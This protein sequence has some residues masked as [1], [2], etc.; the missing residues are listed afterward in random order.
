MYWIRVLIGWLLS[1]VAFLGV[2]K[3]LPGFHIKSFG[4]ALIVSGSI[5]CCTSS[6]TPS[7]MPFGS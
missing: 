2:S 7:S 4:T 6:C 1:A 5:A 3:V